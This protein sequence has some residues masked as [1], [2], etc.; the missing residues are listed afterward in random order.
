M[1]EYR[2][3]AVGMLMIYVIVSEILVLPVSWLPFWIFDTRQRH[4]SRGKNWFIQWLVWRTCVEYFLCFKLR[5]WYNSQNMNYS[6]ENGFAQLTT[7]NSVSHSRQTTRVFR[8]QTAG[9][10]NSCASCNLHVE[11]LETSSI[12]YSA[13]PGADLLQ[14]GESEAQDNNFYWCTPKNTCCRTRDWAACSRRWGWL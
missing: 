2:R 6:P 1:V 4:A 14:Y 9:I 11:A 12:R 8:I 10:T 13:Y 5:C 3:F 7:C